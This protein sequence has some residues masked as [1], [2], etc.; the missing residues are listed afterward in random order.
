MH[1]E[2]HPHDVVVATKRFASDDQLS[3]APVLGLP[4]AYLRY[5]GPL[6]QVPRALKTVKS[7]VAKDYMTLARMLL[8]KNPN[9]DTARAVRFL[10]PSSLSSVPF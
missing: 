6:P 7:K 1:L 10:A 4:A 3:Q 5:I 9:Q 8:G 2:T